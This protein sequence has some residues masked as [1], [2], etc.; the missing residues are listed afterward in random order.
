[1]AVNLDRFSQL[2]IA[3]IFSKKPGGWLH[4]EQGQAE[5][6]LLWDIILKLGVRAQKTTKKRPQTVKKEKNIS[7]CPNKKC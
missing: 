6:L 1:M 3:A 5:V 7:F 4:L 2:P